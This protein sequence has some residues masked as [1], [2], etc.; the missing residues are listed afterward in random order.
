MR[1]CTVSY[2]ACDGAYTDCDITQ[3]ATGAVA[4]RDNSTC[5]TCQ[6]SVAAR[7]A[8]WKMPY[9]W[10][11]R[12]INREDEIEARNW[13]LNMEAVNFP[14]AAYN[15]WK[16]GEW[17][18]SSVHTHFRV[19][20]LDLNDPKIAAT[21]GSY[22]YSGLLASLA[23]SRLMDEEKPDAQLLFNGRMSST[24]I[25]LEL[26]KERGI[27]T[28]CEERCPVVGR[29]RLFDNANCLSVEDTDVLWDAWKDTP[30]SRE[31]IEELATFLRSRWHGNLKDVAVFSHKM[32]PETNVRTQLN[33]SAD[34]PVWVLFTSSMDETID[35]PRKEGV[36][37]SHQAWVEATVEYARRN[38]KV[39]LLIRVHPN[40][41]GSKAL[42]RNS[43]DEEFYKNLAARAPEN[44]QVLDSDNPTSSYTLAAVADVGFIWYSTIGLEMAAMGKP[45]VRAGRSWLAYADFM[46]SASSIESYEALLDRLIG[47]SG[48]TFE[49]DRLVGAWR[50]A[51]VWFYRQSIPFPLVNQP[52]WYVGDPIYESIDELKPGRDDGLDRICSV[53]IDKMPLYGP[54]DPPSSRHK[55]VETEEIS[56]HAAQLIKC[57]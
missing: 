31:E 54:A 11:G 35:K 18:K 4:A 40:A 20:T 41:G 8:T 39:Q 10:I 6:A 51:Y 49:I 7:L 37:P 32:Q 38:P 29:V 23:L 45:V 1:G 52:D 19:N 36:F 34:R 3:Q 47:I 22:L 14:S 50:F 26:A 13:I 42:G 27:R 12:W 15:Q 33:L 57:E 56:T 46:Y 5:L 55:N 53:F 9:R 43:Q 44:V 16:I 24:R 28:I 21:Y 30:L 25:A 17:V 48:K 2:V